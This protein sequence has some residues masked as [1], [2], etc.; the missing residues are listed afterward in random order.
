[1]PTRAVDDWEDTAA[2]VEIFLAD[3][4]TERTR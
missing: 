4:A 3:R 2:F 1:V